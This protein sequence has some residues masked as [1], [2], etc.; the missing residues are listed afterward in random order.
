MTGA[1]MRSVWM[2]WSEYS[3]NSIEKEKESKGTLPFVGNKEDVT[4]YP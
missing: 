2:R 3:F 1:V 4:L